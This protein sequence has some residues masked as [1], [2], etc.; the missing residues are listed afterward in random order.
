MSP[1]VFSPDDGNRGLKNAGPPSD[2]VLD[3]LLKKVEADDL[4]SEVKTLSPEQMRAS[5]EV[6]RVPLGQ[7]TEKDYVV[8]GKPPMIGADCEW[9]W[10]VRVRR[11][12]AEVMLFANGLA[13]ELRGRVA[14]GYR[15]IDVSWASAASVSDRLYRYDGSAYKVVREHTERQKP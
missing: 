6:V 10:I 11:G 2:E 9:F 15:D 3:A 1:I 14:H 8:H 12:K 5:F 7:T 4:D 13:L